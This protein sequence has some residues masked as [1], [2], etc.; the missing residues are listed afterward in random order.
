ML[1]QV[2][3]II[4]A[5]PDTFPDNTLHNGKLCICNHQQILFM[6]ENFALGHLPMKANFG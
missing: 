4:A 1:K 5:S 3:R 2:Q 6:G